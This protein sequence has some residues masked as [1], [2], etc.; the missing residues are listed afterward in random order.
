MGGQGS[1][2]TFKVKSL[3]WAVP[4]GRD[5]KLSSWT[6]TLLDL[7]ALSLL[8]GGLPSGYSTCENFLLLLSLCVQKFI[9]YRVSCRY[10]LLGAVLWLGI[11]FVH[12][13]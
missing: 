10:N 2:L 11:G 9:I 8:A 6:H 1:D 5:C 4:V 3:S 12:Q 13:C 7:Q